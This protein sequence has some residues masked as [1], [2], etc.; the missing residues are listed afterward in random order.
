MNPVELV[1]WVA[2][3]PVVTATGYL[4]LLSLLSSRRRAPK[5]AEPHL[6]F[7]IVVPAHDEE[8]G[9]ADT[10]S[11]LRSLDYPLELYRVTVV[12]DNCSDQTAL[13]AREAGATV[14]ERQDASLRG[15]GY[16]LAEAFERS[17]A[18]GRSDAV[19]VVDADSVVSANLLRAFAARLD[20][21]A[22][23]VQAD[24]G[25]ANPGASWRTRLMAIALSTVHTLR[26]LGRQRLGLSSG[27]HGNGMCFTTDLLRAVPYSSFSIVEDLEYGI[28]LGELG[29]R[30]HFAAEARV[31]GEMPAGERGSRL[32][33]Q[34]WEEG[35]RQMVRRHAWRLL[36]SGI[37]R[38]DRVTFDL[39]MELLVPPL[40]L[41]AALDVLG[42]AAAA[43]LSWAM[44]Y[45]SSAVWVWVGCTLGLGVYG[46]RGW[47]LSRT[48]ARGLTALAAVPAYIFWKL[49]LPLKRSAAG[50]GEW[51]RTPR[52]GETR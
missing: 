17:L 2:A 11:S 44:G 34:R 29:H 31:S 50:R 13:R 33:R 14:I 22:S 7:D 8:Q 18:D 51:V 36:W 39:A 5:G 27:L 38:R 21:G 41:I 6:R 28:H 52:E 19:V 24:Y 1:L 32:Q 42:L 20:A 15:K 49:L 48:G 37:K 26:S 10:V 35:R 43:A 9:I 12:A 46:L 16:A 23:A 30:V 3:L 4:V 40:A 47:Q 25:V 45:W